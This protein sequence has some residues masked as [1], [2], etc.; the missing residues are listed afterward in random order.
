MR[1]SQ[2]KYSRTD[3][4]RATRKQYDVGHVRSAAYRMAHQRYRL[5]RRNYVFQHYSHGTMRCASCGFSDT[6]ALQLDH[7]A[8]DG[9][10]HRRLVRGTQRGAGIGYYVALIRLGLPS[11]FQ[12]L[13]ANCN[14]IKESKRRS[15]INCFC[16]TPS[17][18]GGD[19][20]GWRG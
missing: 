9:A 14:I 15:K 13:C 12:V 1:L 11:G 19:N 10:N 4:G 16:L 20:S 7:I 8:D 3:K 6:R 5:G 18:K 17:V 2:T